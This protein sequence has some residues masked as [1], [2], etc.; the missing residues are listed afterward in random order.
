MPT[1]EYV[2]KACGHR[3]EVVRSMHD[4][5]LTECPDCGGELRKVFTPPTITFKGSGF[6]ATDH[7][8]R[9]GSSAREGDK[10]TAKRGKSDTGEKKEKKDGGSTGGSTSTSG[11]DAGSGASKKEGGS[12]T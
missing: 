5:P 4:A 6:Y 1:Y 11:S 9:S 2:C 8:K 12:G 10:T 7:K 3:F